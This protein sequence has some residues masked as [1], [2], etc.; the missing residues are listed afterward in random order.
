MTT[1]P[2]NTPSLASNGMATGC[3]FQW[4]RSVLVACPQDMLPQTLPSGLCWKTRWETPLWKMSPLGSFIQ[5]VEGLKWYAGR[6]CGVSAAAGAA[7]SAV[8]TARTRRTTANGRRKGER[9]LTDMDEPPVDN[10]VIG[11]FE[12]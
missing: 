9:V 3:S 10:V 8:M 12:G 7:P 6:C 11:E 5:F 2:E 4:T 1:E